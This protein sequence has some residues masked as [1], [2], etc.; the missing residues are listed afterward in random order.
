MR[1]RWRLTRHGGSATGSH[2]DGMLRTELRHGMFGLDGILSKQPLIER[3]PSAM[4]PSL[5]ERTVLCITSNAASLNHDQDGIKRDRVEL[6][7]KCVPPI[8]LGCRQKLSMGELRSTPQQIACT[9]VAAAA[10]SN[11]IRRRAF[12]FALLVVLPAGL[13]GAKQRQSKPLCSFQQMAS[14]PRSDTTDLCAQ[15]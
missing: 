5:P 11:R 4:S 13:P 12:G 14:S 7:P 1:E 6:K 9:K 10:A 15:E 2:K 8:W 3:I